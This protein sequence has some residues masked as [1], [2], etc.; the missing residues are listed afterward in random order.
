MLT[1]ARE[2]ATPDGAEAFEVDRA[3]QRISRFRSAPFHAGSP[4]AR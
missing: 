2:R 3:I 1:R 4:F